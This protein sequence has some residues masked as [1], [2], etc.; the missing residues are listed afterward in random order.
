MVQK[1]DQSY[2]PLYISCREN[3]TPT[4]AYFIHFSLFQKWPHLGQMH[5]F[6][7]Y[8]YTTSK[9][10]A[11]EKKEKS[12][13]KNKMG[14]RKKESVLLFS[15]VQSKDNYLDLLSLLNIQKSGKEVSIL[16]STK[17]QILSSHVFHPKLP[18]TVYNL[19]SQY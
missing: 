18:S 13:R 2:H 9:I 6:Q 15:I 19:T 14:K 12:E 17:E 1:R 5:K 10:P 4:Q 3:P 7:R 16:S 8:F 11:A